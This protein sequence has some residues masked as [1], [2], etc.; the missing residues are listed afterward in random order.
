MQQ[1]KQ[2]LYKKV[3]EAERNPFFLHPHQVTSLYPFIPF[4]SAV[5]GTTHANNSPTSAG[6]FSP[7][8]Y[9]LVQQSPPNIGL[10]MLNPGPSVLTPPS[11]VSA[12]ATLTTQANSATTNLVVSSGTTQNSGLKGSGPGTPPRPPYTA[13]FYTPFMKCPMSPPTPSGIATLSVLSPWNIATMSQ[14]GMASSP[15]SVINATTSKSPTG[16]AQKSSENITTASSQAHESNPSVSSAG[17]WNPA[18]SGNA[19][20]AP[21]LPQHVLSPRPG[22]KSIHSPLSLLH[23]SPLSPM[24][25]IQSPYASSVSSCPSVSSSSGC[26]SD[27][28]A[29]FT[30]GLQMKHYAPSEYHVG[31]RRPLC[32][33]LTEEDIVSEG[34]NSSGR[35]TP[36][37]SEDV[38]DTNPVL[39]NQTTSVFSS[40]ASSSS[41]SAQP[42][43]NRLPTFTQFS[44]TSQGPSI[45]QPINQGQTLTAQGCSTS[46]ERSAYRPGRGNSSSDITSHQPVS[47]RINSVDMTCQAVSY[48]YSVE[49]GGHNPMSVESNSHVSAFMGL[50]TCT[51]SMLVWVIIANIQ[52]HVITVLHS[53]CTHEPRTVVPIT[54]PMATRTLFVGNLE[55]D[56]RTL[57][58]GS[59]LHIEL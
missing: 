13:Q 36:V 45:S 33:K 55:Q 21:I 30:T 20:T 37:D 8:V 40:S 4:P 42:G 12:S 10:T 41:S 46:A 2:M 32:E 56:V 17:S 26:S 44:I 23:A 58:Q 52:L 24:M 53:T 48:P 49:S 25:L 29:S 43:N 34:A 38:E 5:G 14:M 3:A 9:S 39:S 7:G 47:S 15:T 31:P 22:F 59:R 18:A 57:L 50:C 19:T 35:N 28:G 11:S 16:G 51:I 6:K 1:Q 54:D 27:G